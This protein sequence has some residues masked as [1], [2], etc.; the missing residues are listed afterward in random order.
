MPVNQKEAQQVAAAL[1]ILNMLVRCFSKSY[2]DPSEL[3]SIGYAVIGKLI[4]S[5]KCKT[6]WEGFVRI[7]LRNAFRDHLR[8]ENYRRRLLWQNKNRISSSLLLKEE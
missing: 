5:H 1:E 7:S 3:E 4:T 2:H 8:K 6:S